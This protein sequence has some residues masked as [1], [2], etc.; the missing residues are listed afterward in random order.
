MLGYP[1]SGKTTTARIIHEL[2]GAV[3]LWADHVR[4]ERYGKPTYGHRENLELYAHMNELTAELLAAGNSVVFDTNF[5]FHKDRE[6]LRN[7]AKKHG[8]GTKLIWVS[9]PKDVAKARATDGAHQ[10]DTRILGDMSPVD[11]ER[12][13]R[14]LQQPKPDEHYIE[15]DG[16]KVTRDY[17]KKLLA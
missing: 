3:H 8:A 13:A 11:F 15:V 1:G 10:N 9:T 14:N 4:R 7:I 2:T 12:M 6:H 17:I 16:T 5:N